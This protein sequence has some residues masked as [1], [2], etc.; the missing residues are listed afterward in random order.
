MEI[1]TIKKELLEVIGE[2][3]EIP[4]DFDTSL[5]LKMD[6]GLNSFAMMSLAAAIEEHFDISIP[7]ADLMSFKNA[8]DIIKYIYAAKG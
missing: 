5:S 7:N 8:D 4:A 3:V 1:Q 6:A 2:Y